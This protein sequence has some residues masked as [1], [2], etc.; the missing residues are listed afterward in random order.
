MCKRAGSGRFEA[1]R[2]PLAGSLMGLKVFGSS[3]RMNGGSPWPESPGA[4]RTNPALAGGA[5]PELP[6]PIDPNIPARSMAE[7]DYEV[8]T[9]NT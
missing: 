9:L 6:K 2:S 7:T 1:A 3:V 4:S 5:A 8:C